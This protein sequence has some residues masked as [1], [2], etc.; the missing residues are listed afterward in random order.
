MA[1]LGRYKAYKHGYR[2]M[3]LPLLARRKYF[4]LLFNHL[5]RSR[6]IPT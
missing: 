5:Y 2:P 1:V 3:D 4:T 6:S